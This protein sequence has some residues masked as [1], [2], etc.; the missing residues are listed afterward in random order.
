MT[1][2]TYLSNQTFAGG[3]DVGMVQAG[4]KLLHKT[5]DKGGFGMANCLANRHVLGQDWTSQVSPPDQ[6]EVKDADVVVGNP[7]CSGWSV[8]AAKHF[9]GSDSPALSCTWNFAN[10]AAR[11]KPYIAVFE[12]V[13]QAFTHKDGLTVMRQLRELL[14]R[15]TGFQYELFHV[16]H[17]AYGLG[18][19]AK[20]P[21]YFW[22]ASRI[23]FGIEPPL[24]AYPM[25]TFR[26]VINDLAPLDIQWEAQSYDPVAS[27]HPWTQQLVNPAG[28]VDGHVTVNNPLTRRLADLMAGTEWKAGES[29]ASVVKRYYTEHGKLPDSWAATQ[30]K[31]LAKD[32]M[33]G[34]TT[35]TR[36]RGDGPSRVITGGSMQLVIHPDLNRTIT[37]REAAR[38]L[39]FPD[40]WLIDPLR[41]VSGLT[42]TWGKGISTHCGKWI[43]EWMRSALEGNPGSYKG[44]P[45]GDREWDINVTNDWKR[46]VNLAPSVTPQIATVVQ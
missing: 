27:V 32:F 35:P 46:A 45:M 36:W 1:Q 39:G 29:L 7:P 6:W 20:R 30:D 18:G 9:R 17:N 37:H 4:F 22:V 12:S 14:E 43:G 19:C 24:P 28:T 10:Y 40:N 23:P 3:F 31:I 38:V 8:M 42:M 33:L 26:D 11:V 2:Y 15:K 5:E 13:Q 21:R 44:N 16:R 34:F 25:P 41:N